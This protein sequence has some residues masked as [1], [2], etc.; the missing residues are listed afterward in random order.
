MLYYVVGVQSATSCFVVPMAT[1]MA[2][3]LCMLPVRLQRPAARYVIWPRIDQKSCFKS[4]ITAG[5]SQQVHRLGTKHVVYGTNVREQHAPVVLYS[6]AA[7]PISEQ[8]LLYCAIT[9]H[10]HLTL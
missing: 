9:I 8:F 4:I 6:G 10:L 2:L 1:G 7:K 5:T 3:V